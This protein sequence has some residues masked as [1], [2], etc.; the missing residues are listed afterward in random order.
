MKAIKNNAPRIQP[1]THYYEFE[2]A[3]K[4]IF[5]QSGKSDLFTLQVGKDWLPYALKTSSRF[6]EEYFFVFLVLLLK[7][8]FMESN[9]LYYYWDEPEHWGG[10][11][12]I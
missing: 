6:S 12:I 4:K 9:K 11:I 3:R 10:I 7:L 8:L 1:T 2:G 5:L